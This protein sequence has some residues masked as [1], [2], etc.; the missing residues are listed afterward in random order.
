MY[1]FTY[2]SPNAPTLGALL[3]PLKI[4]GAPDHGTIADAQV[5]AAHYDVRIDL[6]DGTGRVRRVVGSD[7]QVRDLKTVW[8]DAISPSGVEMA[9]AR[10]L[11]ESVER[12]GRVAEKMRAAGITREDATRLR[13]AWVKQ[14]PQLRDFYLAAMRHPASPIHVR[15]MARA[16]LDQAEA[17]K[18]AWALGLDWQTE[19]NGAKETGESVSERVGRLWGIENTPSDDLAGLNQIYLSAPP[20]QRERVFV[21]ISAR[22]QAPTCAQWVKFGEPRERS[23]YFVVRGADRAMSGKTAILD[24]LAGLRRL[25]ADMRVFRTGRPDEFE[26]LRDVGLRRIDFWQEPPVSLSYDMVAAFRGQTCPDQ[27]EMKQTTPARARH[28]SGVSV[29][30]LIAVGH[31]AQRLGFWGPN[32]VDLFDT[33]GGA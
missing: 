3:T 20:C 7:G 17:R 15:R 1:D 13:A 26:R 6:L 30:L 32:E 2:R 9:T 14:Y 33:N 4:E 8:F 24:D 22:A 29:D 5:W 28:L 18:W 19:V 31:S 12:M 25:Q 16:E 11:R 10:A 27:F 21:A 23:C